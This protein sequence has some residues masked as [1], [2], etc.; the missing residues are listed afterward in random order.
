MISL[1]QA[2]TPAIRSDVCFR[3]SQDEGNADFATWA[4]DNPAGALRRFQVRFERTESG[5]EISS[6]DQSMIGDTVIITVAYPHDAKAGGQWGRDRD[7][8]IE[9]DW[10]K[11]NKA[12]GAYGRA[13]F[14][15]TND[16]T[17]DFAT[18]SVDP[19]DACDF[20]RV[21]IPVTFYIDVAA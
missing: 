20:L 3:H 15:G 17:P 8:A 10:F 1:V 11:I 9:R 6:V 18:M 4:E 19:G 21:E 14:S 12:C 5:P 13:N 16:C 7:D 2:I